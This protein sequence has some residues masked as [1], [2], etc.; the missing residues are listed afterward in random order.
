VS[1]LWH[2]ANWT[3]IIWGALHGFYQVLGFITADA[4]NAVVQWVGLPKVPWLYNLLQAGV[5]F[6]LVCFA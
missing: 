5:T 3:F 1:G 2:G 4:R 6:M